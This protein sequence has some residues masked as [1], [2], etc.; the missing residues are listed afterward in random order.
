V[1]RKSRRKLWEDE[2]EEDYLEIPGE[3]DVPDLESDELSEADPEEL[4]EAY[5]QGVR[6]HRRL[7]EDRVQRK[8]QGK[9]QKLRKG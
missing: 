4:M 9:R 7:K 1:T 6:A 2:N 3:E 5:F 8:R